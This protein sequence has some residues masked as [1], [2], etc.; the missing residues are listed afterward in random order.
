MTVNIAIALLYTLRVSVNE[1]PYLP[2]NL[3]HVAVEKIFQELIQVCNRIYTHS[4]HI[5][6]TILELYNKS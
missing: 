5:T 1:T 2:G 6:Y 4:K 3:K